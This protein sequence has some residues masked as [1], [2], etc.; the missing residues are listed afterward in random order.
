[1]N[2]DKTKVQFR[3]RTQDFFSLVTVIDRVIY[4]KE[5][6]FF[7]LYFNLEDVSEAD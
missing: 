2:R 4:D 3:S 6:G 5:R 7:V 1:M